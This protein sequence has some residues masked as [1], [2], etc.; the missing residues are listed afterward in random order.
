MEEGVQEGTVPKATKLIMRP[1][2]RGLEQPQV[3]DVLFHIIGSRS[4][5]FSD[6][7]EQVTKTFAYI[8]HITHLVCTTRNTWCPI[9]SRIDLQ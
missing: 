2:P 4:T 7:C 5:L 9:T 1:W 3:K 8:T 6:H